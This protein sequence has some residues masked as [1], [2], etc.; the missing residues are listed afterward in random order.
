MTRDH[1]QVQDLVDRGLLSED[2]ARDHPGSNVITRAI[3][4]ADELELDSEMIKIA[5]GDTFVLCSDGLTSEVTDEE[6]V[7]LVD[8]GDCAGSADTLIETAVQRG[9]RDNV[10]AVVVR[11]DPDERTVL[12]PNVAEPDPNTDPTIPSPKR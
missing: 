10:T 4:V 6:I 12:N 2:K 1:S 8:P 3:G 5:A 9:A 7:E 11:A